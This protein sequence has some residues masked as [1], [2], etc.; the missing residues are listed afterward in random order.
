MPRCMVEA[1]GLD[2]DSH[3]LTGRGEAQTTVTMTTIIGVLAVML[4]FWPT[5]KA[6]RLRHKMRQNI[7]RN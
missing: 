6:Q 4:V 3:P 7:V 2:F 5:C 1:Y